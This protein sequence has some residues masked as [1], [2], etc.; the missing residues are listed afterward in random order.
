MFPYTLA[1]SMLHGDQR[2]ISPA[3]S[4]A[5]VLTS[6]DPVVIDGGR[7]RVPSRPG[8]RAQMQPE[9]LSRFAFA[10]GAEWRAIERE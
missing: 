4:A 10:A 3:T 5:E 8:Y 2:S 1:P 9:T 6:E 7:Y